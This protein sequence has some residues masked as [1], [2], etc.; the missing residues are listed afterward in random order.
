M[1]KSFFFLLLF[2][3][4]S[5][6]YATESFPQGCYLI[7]KLVSSMERFNT[8]TPECVEHLNGKTTNR[9]SCEISHQYMRKTFDIYDEFQSTP[10]LNDYELEHVCKRN[11]KQDELI[12]KKYFHLQ[13]EVLQHFSE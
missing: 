12:I 10:E 3:L 9:R 1:Y 13:Q 7:E 5:N 6:V 4:S 2:G 11:L 8:I